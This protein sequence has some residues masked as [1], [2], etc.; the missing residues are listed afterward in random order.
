MPGESCPGPVR[1]PGEAARAGDA[2]GAS[3]ERVSFWAPQIRLPAFIF[4][5]LFNPLSFRIILLGLCGIP[6]V[7]S[8]ASC[9]IPDPAAAVIFFIR[10]MQRACHFGPRACLPDKSPHSH[11]RKSLHISAGRPWRACP[12]SVPSRGCDPLRRDGSEV[13]GLTPEKGN[14][15]P[16]G[17]SICTVPLLNAPGLS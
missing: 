15:H 9:H 4:L 10:S 14:H 2:G 16:A 7:S 12:D 13:R 8:G 11:L 3:R 17:D 6:C 5:F 1:V